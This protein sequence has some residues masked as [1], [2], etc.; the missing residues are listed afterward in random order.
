MENSGS[1]S[2]LRNA[3]K[4]LSASTRRDISRQPAPP[5]LSVEIAPLAYDWRVIGKSIRGAS[6]F[7]SGLPNQDAIGWSP[8]SGAARELVIAVSDGHGS[9]KYF[10]SGTGA[11]LAVQAALAEGQ[12]L[13]SGQPDFN[14]SAIKRTAE[15]HLP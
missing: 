3:L 7:R 2:W 15:E 4:K 10:R 11:A 6:H 8:E 9:A 14:L 1:P 12:N 5:E 13:I